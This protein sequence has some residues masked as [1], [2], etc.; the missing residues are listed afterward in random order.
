M[1]KN[2]TQVTEKW[3]TIYKK[4]DFS[5]PATV[6]VENSFL[7]PEKGFAL[8]LASG[9][10][11]NALFLAAKGLQTEAWDISAIAL[12][13]LSKKGEQKNL[14]LSV[15]QV[16][17][18][19][20]T[21][22]SNAFDVIVISRFL[23]RSL[24]HAI[25]KCL[26]QDGLLFYQTYVQEKIDLSGPKNSEFLLARNELLSLFR[27]LKLLV[28]KEHSLVGDLTFGN[29]NEAFFVGQKN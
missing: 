29:R 10:G 13:K 28:Y 25:I 20:D 12:N 9:L 24:S 17:I 3:D 16:F 7:L 11:A 14:K 8:D 19:S 27:A 22:P 18:E 23:D 1:G 15:K 6:L 26:K 21:L 5:M 4:N 2:I